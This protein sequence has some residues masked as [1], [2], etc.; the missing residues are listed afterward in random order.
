MPDYI[1]LLPRVQNEERQALAHWP[2][3]LFN[4]SNRAQTTLRREPCL[5]PQRNANHLCILYAGEYWAEARANDNIECLG[6]L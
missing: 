5:C 3:A 1:T 2:D 6:L 4:Q